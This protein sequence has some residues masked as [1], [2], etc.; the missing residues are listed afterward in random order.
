MSFY[1]WPE[2]GQPRTEDLKALHIDYD[3]KIKCISV[4]CPTLEC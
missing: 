2:D 1:L 3:C 4:Y